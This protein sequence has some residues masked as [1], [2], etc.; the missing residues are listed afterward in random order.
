MARSDGP[1]VVN[2]FP[3]VGFYQRLSK[4]LQ[5]LMVLHPPDIDVSSFLSD[6]EYTN[7]RNQLNSNQDITCISFC[8]FSI[9]KHLGNDAPSWTA[10]RSCGPVTPPDLAEPAKPRRCNLLGEKTAWRCAIFSIQPCKKRLHN[11]TCWAPKV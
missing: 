8:F 1:Q 6:Y 10:R 9:R 7:V 2:R 4:H 11:W 3:I 5:T